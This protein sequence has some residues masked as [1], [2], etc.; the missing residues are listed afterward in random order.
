MRCIVDDV[1]T[2][3]HEDFEASDIEEVIERLKPAYPDVVI[4]EGLIWPDEYT[5]RLATE[6][7]TIGKIEGADVTIWRKRTP[8]QTRKAKMTTTANSGEAAEPPAGTAETV[9]TRAQ[10]EPGASQESQ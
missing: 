1:Y 7:G 6:S 8:A 2:G 4:E 3:I 5:K 9:N 10:E